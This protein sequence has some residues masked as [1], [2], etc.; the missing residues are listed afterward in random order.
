MRHGEKPKCV[1]LA[2]LLGLPV[3][4]G[5]DSASGRSRSRRGNPLYLGAVL[6]N[7]RFPGNV[8]VR[9][10]SATS[11]AKSLAGHDADLDPARSD[12]SRA[13]VGRSTSAM[14]ADIKLAAADLVAAVNSM[15]TAD[16][17]RQIAADRSARVHDYTAGMTNRCAKRSLARFPDSRRADQ[18]E[19][20]AYELE[21]RLDRDTI[22]V[23][24]IDSGKNMDP[25][26]S[27]GGERQTYFGNGPN[28]LGWGM[29]AGSASSSRG[30][31][32]RWLR[33]SATAA[34]LFGGPQPLWSQARYKAPGHDHRAEQS[35]L[36]QRAQPHLDVHLRPAVQVGPRHDVLQRFARRRFRQ[37]VPSVRR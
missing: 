28:I 21:S 1:E 12:E 14:V 5:G 9:S 19:R 25:F 26:M 3:A 4:G 37:S 20:L 11:T 36:Q 27:F 23:N 6:R 15:A 29:S 7:M 10:I 18:L 2:E 24:D 32:R 31:T 34:F 35:Q 16:R 33:S 17:L 30:P 22:Y 8:D 13:R